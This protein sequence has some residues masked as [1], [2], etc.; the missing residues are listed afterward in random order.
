MATQSVTTQTA[1]F[2]GGCFWCTASDL[3]KTP[4][5]LEVVSGYTGGISANPTYRDVCTGQ[6]GHYEAVQVHFDPTKIAYADLLA[7]FWRTIDP[8]DAGGQF[9]DRGSQ[10]RTAIFYHDEVQRRLA[11]EAKQALERSGR[12]G[13]PVATR[14]L[15]LTAF[16]PAETY[17]QQFHLKD[18]ARYRS[19]RVGSGRDRLLAAIWGQRPTAAATSKEKD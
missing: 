11:E 12:F 9:V 18:P 2:A 7:I 17:H 8:T 1:T 3:A 14:I 15:P 19:Y 13:H 6:T 16:H 4:G 5:V 10:Y